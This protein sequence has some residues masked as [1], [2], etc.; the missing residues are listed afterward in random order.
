MNSSKE[1]EPGPGSYATR[2]GP[3]YGAGRI[4]RMASREC[5]GYVRGAELQEFIRG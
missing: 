4:L 2:F 5:E 3:E 1:P